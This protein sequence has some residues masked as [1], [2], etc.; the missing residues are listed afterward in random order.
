MCIGLPKTGASRENRQSS[1]LYRK[2]YPRWAQGP[3]A[4][5]HDEE[6]R[7]RSDLAQKAYADLRITN[8]KPPPYSLESDPIGNIWELL[9]NRV[10]QTGPTTRE[11]I[12][13]RVAG[14]VHGCPPK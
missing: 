11:T 1:D 5:L 3:Q 10:K 2:H 9:D 14:R 12:K 7:L 4:V 8:A 13:A 6:M